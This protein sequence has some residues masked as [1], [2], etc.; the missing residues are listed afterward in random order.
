MSVDYR[1]APQLAARLMGVALVG[2]GVTVCVATLL[3]AVFRLPL[4]ALTAV[5]V[6]A[7]AMVLVGGLVLGRR[8]FVVRLTPEGYRV[9][10]V[11][12]A[13][14]KQGRWV[15][16]VDAVTAQVGGSPC[17]V[18]RLRDG[19]STTIPVEVL[20]GDREVFARDVQQHLRSGQGERPL[21]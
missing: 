10:F 5:V 8:G 2:V 21:S 18:L 13:G 1:L 16:V 20:A 17:L 9:R 11:R 6:L 19:R 12:G 4:E 7:L 15:D 14:V 3:I